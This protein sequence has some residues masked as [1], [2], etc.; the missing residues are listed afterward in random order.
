MKNFVSRLKAYA[1]RLSATAMIL[2]ALVSLTAADSFFEIDKNLSIFSELYK[3]LNNYYVDETKPGDLMKKGI[4]AM[5]ESLDPY[6]NYYPEE[7]I[8]DY[9]YMTTGQYGGIGAVVRTKGENVVIA[10]PYKGYAAAKAGLMA[11]DVIVEVNGVSAK[12]KT[13]DDI[14]KV[15]KGQPNTSVRLKIERPGQ[16]A[17]MEVT[18]VREEVKVKN[19]P[20]YNILS[21]NIGYIKLTGFTEDAGKEVREAVTDLKAK[22][23]TGF[24]LDLRGNP[25]GLLREAVDIVNIFEDK[26]TKVVNTKGKVKEWDKE[27]RCEKVVLD[28]SSPLT[29]LVDR[30]SASA[31]EIVSGALQDLDRGVVV[32]QRS[33][34]KGLVQQTVPL[35]FNAQ[36]KVTVAKYYIPSGRCVQALDYSHR[37]KNGTVGKVPDSLITAY[38]TVNNN[39]TVWDGLGVIPDIKVK[40]EKMS[41]VAVSLLNKSLIFDYATQYKLSHASI[42]AAKDFKLTDADFQDFVTF[43]KGKDYTYTTKTEKEL[44]DFKKVA[45]KEKYFDAVKTQ[46]ESLK[47]QLAANKQDDIVK[48][49]DEIMLLLQ[50]EIASRYYYAD[51]RIEA[52]LT[53]DPVL[54]EAKKV[55][56]DSKRYKELL[57]TSTQTEKPKQDEDDSE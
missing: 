14:S 24:I 17:P 56:L 4:D 28:G 1:V 16:T 53:N 32:G 13:Y 40:K 8:E 31:S 38:K 12:G 39:R 55:L 26:G 7:N 46:Y 6:T 18:L 22:G 41:N 5:L 29:V 35:A 57:T 27:H 54:E 34:G 9:R 43:L 23:A 20:Y 2:I 19:V 30:G 42:V 47:T 49:K 25:G 21:D 48:Q 44:E 11:G 10:E 3:Q 51:G 33:F 36:L 37:D 52:S 15:L 50:Q 45:E